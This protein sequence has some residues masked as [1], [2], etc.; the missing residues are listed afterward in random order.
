MAYLDELRKRRFA[1]KAT[2]QKLRLFA[3]SEEI[4]AVLVVEGE[5]DSSVYIDAFNKNSNGKHARIIICNGKGGVLGLRDFADLDFP[6][7]SKLMF[8]VDRDHDDFLGLNSRDERTYVTDHYSIEWNACTEDIMYSL[9]ARHYTLSAHDPV[10]ATVREKFNELMAIWVNHALPIMQG[11][12]FARRAGETLDLEQIT[13][14]DIC[15][16]RNA[17]FER[18]EYE[19]TTIL[20]HAGA[21]CCPERKDLIE[22]KAEFL[23]HDYKQSIRGKLVVQF[24]CEFFRK[25]GTICGSPSKIDGQSL[26]T[27][28]QIGKNNYFQFVLDDWVVPRS[29]QIFFQIWVNKQDT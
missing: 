17:T 12:V 2:E 4:H 11:V 19:L 20:G 3:R 5:E 6:N 8:F 29:L 15:R 14:S 26:S 16:L 23:G 13:L 24:F 27:N 21:Q 10:W 28:V 9:V 25:L 22:G 1:S 18:T 7:H